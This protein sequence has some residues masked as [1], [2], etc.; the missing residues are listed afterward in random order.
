MNM[1]DTSAKYS[2]KTYT[3]H[4]TI[5][6]NFIADNNTISTFHPLSI[7]ETSSLE[8][9]RKYRGSIKHYAEACDSLFG[10]Q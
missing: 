7:R 10:L 6:I 2:G 1:N 5:M 4:S 9:A 3:K 8:Y